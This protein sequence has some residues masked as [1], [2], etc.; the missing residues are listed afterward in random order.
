MNHYN[1]TER[2]AGTLILSRLKMFNEAVVFFEQ[3]IDPAFWKGFDQC[4][5]RFLKDNRWVGKASCEQQDYCWLA[6]PGWVIEGVNCKYWFENVSQV[7]K[8]DDFSLAVLIGAGTEQGQIGFQFKLNAGHFGGAKMLATYTSAIQENLR[9]QLIGAGF[10][11][12]GKGNFFLPVTLDPKQLVESWQTYGAFP[13][14][15]ELF[16]PLR[17]ALAKLLLSAEILD[18]IFSSKVDA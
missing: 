9:Q 4:V 1:D 17:T 10:T 2:Q 11:D 3:H 16:D 13:I 18:A 14:E 8:G 5:D 6:H 12:Q 15:H 7:S